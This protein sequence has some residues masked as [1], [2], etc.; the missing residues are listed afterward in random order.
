[1]LQYVAVGVGAV[2]GANF[3]YFV[4]SWATVRW[5]AAFPYGT[6]IINITGAFA[7]GLILSAA[8]TRLDANP[9]LRLF[10][11]TGLLGGYTTFSSYAWEALSLASDAAWLRFGA[12]VLASNLVGLLG[13]WA[14]SQLGAGILARAAEVA[15]QA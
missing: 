5:G 10:F 12:Y 11:I 6:F 2:I 9:L 15:A 1:V 8:A 13:V 4:S 3:R 7:I 14:G